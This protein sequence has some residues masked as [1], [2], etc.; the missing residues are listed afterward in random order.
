LGIR[1]SK[2]L[3]SKDD[4]IVDVLEELLAYTRF[5]ARPALAATLEELLADPKHF[6]AYRASDGS[7]GQKE[8][9]EIV[10]VSQPTVS[11]LWA[12]WRRLGVVRNVGG[13]AQLL[14]DPYDLGITPPTSS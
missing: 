8:V 6:A 7:R 5:A 4:R 9:A 14:M 2:G 13:K 10:G 1:R 12:R 3:H 11:N